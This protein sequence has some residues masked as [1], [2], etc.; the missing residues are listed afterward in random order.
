M[1]WR[2]TPHESTAARLRTRRCCA[3]RDLSPTLHLAG[4]VTPFYRW[5]SQDQQ[6]SSPIHGHTANGRKASTRALAEFT[7]EPV[8]REVNLDRVLKMNWIN[9]KSGPQGGPPTWTRDTSFLNDLGLPL[10]SQGLCSLLHKE[11]PG[12]DF[13]RSKCASVPK[14]APPGLFCPWSARPHHHTNFPYGETEAQSSR[15]T[16]PRLHKARSGTWVCLTSPSHVLSHSLTLV[17]RKTAFSSVQE[18]HWAANLTIGH[19]LLDVCRTAG[20]RLYRLLC[21][22]TTLQHDPAQHQLCAQTMSPPCPL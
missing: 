5:G 18:K 1:G 10:P 16:F 15:M 12:L 9:R 22:A 14:A 3:H 4:L 7:P 11:G 8:Q 13:P 19:L 17:G 6:R 20:F 21:G 2:R